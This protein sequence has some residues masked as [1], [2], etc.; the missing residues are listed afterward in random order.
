MTNSN[1]ITCPKCG[2]KFA[3][4]EAFLHQAEERFKSQYEEKAAE[5]ENALSEKL[6]ELEADRIKLEQQK[7]AQEKAIQEKVEKEKAKLQSE[8]EKSIREEFDQH[9]ESLQEENEKRKTENRELKKKE[10]ELLQKASDLK[11]R[12]EELKLEMQKELLNKEEEIAAKVRQKEQE[13]NELTIRDYKE[14]LKNQEKMIAEM[15]NQLKQGSMKMQGSVQ[16]LALI[17]FLTA[18]YPYDMIENVPSGAKGAD[19]IQTIKNDVGQI[20]GKIIYESKR[21]KSFTAEWITKLK[22]DQRDQQADLAVIVTESMPKDM[23]HFGSRERVWICKFHEVKGLSFALREMLI[24]VHSVGVAEVDKS[25]KMSLLY[26]YLTSAEFS[27]RIEAIVEGFSDMKTDIDKEKRA[28]AKI[29]K[30]REKQIEKVISNTI[31]MYGSIKGIAGK[32]V[33]TVK[34]LELPEPEE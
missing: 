13:K 32:A 34:A 8:A 1:N 29:W 12:E 5:Q 10:I 24:N 21:T 19:V 25:D 23:N 2:H 28:M 4:D 14:K 17:D 31:D 26:S 7:K 3:A 33:G 27:Q 16:E 11:E 18:E 15:D 30:A 9:I 6:K 22:N 20:C